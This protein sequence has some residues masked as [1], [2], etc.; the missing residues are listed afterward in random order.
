MGLKNSQYYAIMRD[1][2]RKQLKSHDIQTAIRK[3]RNLRH[4]TTLSPSSPFNTASGFS[5]ETTRRSLR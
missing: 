5:T 4:W 1:Y 2:E 3:S